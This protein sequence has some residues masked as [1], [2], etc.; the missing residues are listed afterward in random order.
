M[1][2]KDRILG[3]GGAHGGI[4]GNMGLGGMGLGMGMDGSVGIIYGVVTFTVVD[5]KG[6]PLPGYVKIYGMAGIRQIAE[7][8]TWEVQNGKGGSVIKQKEFRVMKGRH[9][10]E[11]TVKGLNGS[12]RGLIWVMNRVDVPVTVNV[13][14]GGEKRE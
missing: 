1:F 9:P 5:V 4:L 2:M 13:E 14:V 12:Y 11:I 3:Q 8:D 10:Y 7:G 6:N